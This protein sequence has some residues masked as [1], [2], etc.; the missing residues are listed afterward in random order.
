MSKEYLEKWLKNNSTIIP[1]TNMKK[2]VVIEIQSTMKDMLMMKEELYMRLQVND[3]TGDIGY[4]ALTDINSK[5]NDKGTKQNNGEDCGVVYEH[6]EENLT[7][8]I[9]LYSKEQI[10]KYASS[11]ENKQLQ[12]NLK[13]LGFYSNTVATDGN[14][15][16][17]ESIRAIKIFRGSMG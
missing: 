12:N 11:A 15:G 6:N 10:M 16:S 3:A 9:G 1:F 8:Q 14:L 13:I 17:Q 4:K 7:R 5:R 2:Y